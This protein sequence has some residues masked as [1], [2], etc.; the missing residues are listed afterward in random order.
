MKDITIRYDN[1]DKD[2]TERHDTSYVVDITVIPHLMKQSKFEISVQKFAAQHRHGMY[3]WVSAAQQRFYN[4]AENVNK[5]C[6][7]KMVEEYKKIIVPA[8]AAFLKDIAKNKSTKKPLSRADMRRVLQAIPSCYLR[9]EDVFG[10]YKEL[11]E[12]EILMI[13]EEAIESDTFKPKKISKKTK[14]ERIKDYNDLLQP[15]L[16]SLRKHFIARSELSSELGEEEPPL[17]AHEEKIKD[18]TLIV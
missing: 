3:K 8:V 1:R 4:Y 18:G 17:T 5:Y 16:N 2:R 10:A 11:L 13:K 15:K 7:F 6:T 12:K 14:D 9:S